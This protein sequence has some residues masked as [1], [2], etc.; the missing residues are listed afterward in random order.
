MDDGT[1]ELLKY[2][3]VFV[4]LIV[5]FYGGSQ[6]LKGVLGTKYPM[7]VVVSQS[8]VPTLG[9]GDFILVEAIPD[10]DQVMA[11]PP[12]DGDILVFLRSGATDEYVV[13]RAIDKLEHNG[14]TW[15]VTK[16]DYNSNPDGAPLTGDRILGKVKAR[17]PV[18]GYFSLFIKTM[19]GF[20]LVAV[21]MGV[22]FFFDYLLPP[23]DEVEDTGRFPW[24]SVVPFLVAPAVVVMFWNMAE[25]HLLWELVAVGAWYLGCLVVPLAFWD[26]DMGLM[27]WLYHLVLVMIPISCDIVWWTERITP[28]NWWYGQGS[29][30]PI[31]WLLMKE[32]PLFQEAFLLILRLLTPGCIIFLGT[33]Y[34]KRRGVGPLVKASNWMRR[35]RGVGA[36]VSSGIE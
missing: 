8:M 33:M 34:A 3:S 24:P 22:A 28:S 9:V 30:V 2:A 11:A 7:M 4:A 16:G 19:K 20:G 13:H 32:T 18:L 27:F 12:P 23:K 21:L 14:I 6:L 25:G 1:R 31:T 35:V 36:P 5:A 10:L 29:T 15:Y 17:V 26:D